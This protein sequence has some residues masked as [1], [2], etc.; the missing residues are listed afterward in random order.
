MLLFCYIITFISNSK[1]R[2]TNT[3]IHGETGLTDD[4]DEKY[5][6][7]GFLIAIEGIDGAGKTT[8]AKLLVEKLKSE[9][10]SAIAL[11]EPTEGMW[12]QKIMTQAKDKKFN[13]SAK[14][15]LKLFL[16][17]RIEDVKNNI[18]PALKAKQ[19]V[20][21]DRYYFSSI[22]YQGARGLNIKKIEEINKEIA[23]P[24]DLMIILDVHPLV[25]L[26]R[27]EQKHGKA[28]TAF[29]KPELLEKAREIFN[30]FADRE[31]VKIVEDNGQHS[32]QEIANNIWSHVKPFIFRLTTG[33][34]SKVDKLFK[35]FYLLFNQHNAYDE[36]VLAIEK[37]LINLL[38]PK[39]KTECIPTYCVYKDTD[40]C[41]FIIKQRNYATK[42]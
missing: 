21:M 27:L 40:T 36:N 39:G 25:S 9:G 7:R 29:E 33:F 41:D 30:T 26:Q 12:G 4:T 16:Q 28:L 2:I 35:E 8:Q 23:P 32:P 6:S 5:L 19:I 13:V 11:H 22:A 1:Y 37:Q 24:P 42:L 18:T 3:N 10:Y 15:E 20:V 14:E 31:Y 38:C 17:D 34:D